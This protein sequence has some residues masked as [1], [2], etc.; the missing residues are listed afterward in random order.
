MAVLLVAGMRSIRG[1]FVIAATNADPLAGMA[2]QG[3]ASGGLRIQ[4]FLGF[5]QE[6]RRRRGQESHA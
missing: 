6:P 1:Y 3:S 4:N 5:A 2:L